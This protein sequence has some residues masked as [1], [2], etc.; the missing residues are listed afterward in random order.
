MAAIRSIH[1]TLSRFMMP[2]RSEA[3]HRQAYRYGVASSS[4]LLKIKS[5]FCKKAL[6]KRRYSAKET[7]DFKE[8]TNRSHPISD[9]GYPYAHGYLQQTATDCNRLQQT[10]TDC[11]TL[12]HT[13]THCNTLQHTATN[14]YE[15]L[16]TDIRRRTDIR[17][18]NAAQPSWKRW[19]EN[20]QKRTNRISK[21]CWCC[22]CLSA[23][24]MFSLL[25]KYV[26]CIYQ[27]SWH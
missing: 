15:Y 10:A 23:L 19:R 14:W 6:W 22:I 20:T 2:I 17:L 11:N 9:V 26:D 16:R 1:S 12:Q 27:Y 21:E 3:R 18:F 7:Y 24:C 13:A 8:P 5:L 25:L 4:R